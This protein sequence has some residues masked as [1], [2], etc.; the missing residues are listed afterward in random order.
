M[1]YQQVINGLM[2]GASYSLVDIR[3]G[4]NV[5]DWFPGDHLR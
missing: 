3:D 4:Q 5:V 1:I 2:L